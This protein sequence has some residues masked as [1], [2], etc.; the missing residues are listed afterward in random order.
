MKKLLRCAGVL[1][2]LLGALASFPR[3]TTADPVG[4]TQCCND[5]LDQYR[6]CREAGINLDD[7][8]AVFVECSSP[9]NDP[10]CPT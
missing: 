9:C 5:C 8:Y 3:T 2:I 1:G 6:A 10:F 4:P 7:C